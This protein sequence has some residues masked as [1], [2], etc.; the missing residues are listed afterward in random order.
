MK[1]SFK[2]LLMLLA[3]ITLS[4]IMPITVKAAKFNASDV[5]VLKKIA[6]T[7]NATGAKIPDADSPTSAPCYDWM[8]INGEY[9][10][11]T[12]RWE[13]LGITGKVSFSGLSELEDLWC[14]DNSITKIDVS[15]NKKLTRIFAS[16]NK[17]TSLNLTNNPNLT[18]VTCENNQLKYI[19]VTKCK[20][21]E[22][23]NCAGNKLESLNITKN[24][25]LEILD[26][27]NNK[28]EKLNITKCPKLGLLVCNKNKIQ[29]LNATACPDIDIECDKSVEIIESQE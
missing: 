13:N 17:I 1:K 12:I 6:K 9:R 2:K 4:M 5:A 23:L 20:K 27:K 10:V 3:V 16:N 25:N 14:S 21:L 11:V 7:Q 18:E 15:K 26:C 28:L 19:N 22:D 24:K 8:E 29:K